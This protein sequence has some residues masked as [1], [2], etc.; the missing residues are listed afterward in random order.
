MGW[1]PLHSAAIRGHDGMVKVLMSNGADV[2]KVTNAG[3]SP[4]Y[5][6][7]QKGY[8]IIVKLLLSRVADVNQLTSKGYS[9]LSLLLLKLVIRL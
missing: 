7:A 5:H 4:L 1:S 2:N 9:S 8:H 3:E 6:A